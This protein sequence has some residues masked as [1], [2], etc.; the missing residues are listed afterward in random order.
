MIE[1][2][3]DYR[4]VTGIPWKWILIIVGIIIVGVVLWQTGILESLMSSFTE[5]VV[6]NS[7]AEPGL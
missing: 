2:L 4:E 3:E 1:T 5:S 6:P 7:G